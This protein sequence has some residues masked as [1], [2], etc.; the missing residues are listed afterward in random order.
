MPKV[1][2]AK[3]NYSKR[4]KGTSPNLNMKE[5]KSSAYASRYSSSLIPENESEMTKKASYRSRY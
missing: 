2:K 1:E 4:Y 5:Q 3:S